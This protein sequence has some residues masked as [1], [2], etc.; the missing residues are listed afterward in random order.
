MTTIKKANLDYYLVYSDK[1]EGSLYRNTS[2]G[3]SLPR[4]ITVK[5]QTFID[6]KTKVSSRRTVVRY[7]RRVVLAD[8]SIGV[9]SGYLVVAV[10]VN[11]AVT[12][13]MVN[14][15]VGLSLNMHDHGAEFTDIS[16]EVFVNQG[17]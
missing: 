3:A 8:G 2:D 12:T 10:P 14:D 13:A 1:T 9:V 7:D 15:C 5:H 6:S 17:Q 16:Q 4:E 11:S